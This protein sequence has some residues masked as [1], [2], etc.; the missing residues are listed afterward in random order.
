MWSSPHHLNRIFLYT[1]SI[2]P[3]MEHHNTRNVLL[4]HKGQST[5]PR[6]RTPQFALTPLYLSVRP[7][8]GPYSFSFPPL[9]TYDFPVPLSPSNTIAG[10]MAEARRGHSRQHHIKVNTSMEIERQCPFYDDLS[11]EK[12][13]NP[14]IAIIF[15]SS[16][17]STSNADTARQPTLFPISS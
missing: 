10:G 7:P 11:P 15:F 14:S 9:S 6:D 2:L 1:L 13:T 3:N 12:I 17:L 8:H 16:F 4:E 5:L